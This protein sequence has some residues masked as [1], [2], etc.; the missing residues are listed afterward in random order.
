[1]KTKLEIFSSEKLKF[2][3]TNL[4]SLYDISHKT[5][6]DL[7]DFYNSKHLSIVFFENENFVEEKILKKILQNENFF[8]VSKE[9]SAFEKLSKDFKK[10]I[11]PPLS[12]SKFLDKVNEIINQKKITFK[13]IDFN[14]NVATNNITKEKI[15][16]TQAENLILSKLLNEKNV[17]K[18]LLEREA[19]QIKENL[20][21]SSMESHLNRIR[22]KLK[23]IRSDFTVSS[24]ENIVF[25]EAI[26]QDK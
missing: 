20:N 21:T 4:S 15:Y 2:F 6:N 5:H 19:L 3:F 10:K 13:N 12:I 9:Y 22:K 24:K 14:N 7:K 25:L 23:T 1:M 17:N 11:T 8:F 18:K 26:N 16:L